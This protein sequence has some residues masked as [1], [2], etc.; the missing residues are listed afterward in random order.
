MLITSEQPK[1]PVAEAYRVLRTSVQFAG[2]N[3]P[4]RTILVT[5]AGPGEGKSTVVANLGAALAQA[6]K[7]VV[8][9]DAD[10]RRPTLHR[11]FEVVGTRGLTNLLLM[12]E[13][14]LD[15][16]IFDTKVQN[17]RLIPSGPLPPNP[18]ELLGSQR[19]KSV[20]QVLCAEADFVLFDTPP[21][22]PVTDAAVLSSAVDG[23]MFVVDAGAVRRD[24]A[25]RAAGMLRQLGANVFGGVINKLR[26][27][28]AGGYY[29]YDYQYYTPDGEKKSNRRHRGESKPSVPEAK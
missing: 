2:V 11:I 14:K 28:R 3:K 8:L 17:L 9:V 25:A 23:V 21:I 16:C 7:K 15:G 10:L 6:G 19:L 24:V 4:L 1:S 20:V 12:D 22:L 13:V 29:Y 27:D 5:S 18:S 26:A